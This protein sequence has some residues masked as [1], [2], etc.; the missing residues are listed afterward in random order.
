MRNFWIS[1]L[2]LMFWAIA[3]GLLVEPVSRS[4]ETLR[5]GLTDHDRAALN[6]LIESIR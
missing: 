6:L 4:N 2:A 5:H 3:I 1:G